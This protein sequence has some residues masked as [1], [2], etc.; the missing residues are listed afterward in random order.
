MGA[1]ITDANTGFASTTGFSID[2]VTAWMGDNLLSLF[3]G[4]GLALLYS[5]RYWIVALI[6]I[7]GIVYFAFRAFQFFRH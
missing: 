5:L 3:I 6:I 7:S 2:S 1:L 4:S